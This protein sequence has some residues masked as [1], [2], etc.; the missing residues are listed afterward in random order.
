MRDILG[1][2][3]YIAYEVWGIVL[4]FYPRGL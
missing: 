4:P 2:I 1:L 3:A